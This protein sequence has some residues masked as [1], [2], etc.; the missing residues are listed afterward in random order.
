MLSSG[1]F[2]S[3]KK[4]ILFSILTLIITIPMLF[5]GCGLL[6]FPTD[7]IIKSLGSYYDKE[8]YSH[9]DFQDYTD[10]AKYY[11]INPKTENNER[12]SKMSETDIKEFNT[13]LEDFEGW[14]NTFAE[15]D[16]NDELAVNYDFD[17]SIISLDDYLAIY[18]DPEYPSQFG[19]YDIYFLDSETNI[20]YYFHH[21]I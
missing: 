8:F 7:P 17:R 15:N 11:Y 6:F 2:M 1:D 10:Y 19:N 16:P 4:S 21:N 13:Y 9:G 20:L 5:S 12:I 18:Y 14:V 3:K